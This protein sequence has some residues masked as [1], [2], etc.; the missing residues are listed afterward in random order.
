MRKKCLPRQERA[1]VLP[2]MHRRGDPQTAE[3]VLGKEDI[4]RS[5]ENPPNNLQ[6][7]EEEKLGGCVN[8]Q[9]RRIMGH[10]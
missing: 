5:Q 10:P 4:Y 3:T 7:G 8:C 2:N 6:L 1:S 9:P